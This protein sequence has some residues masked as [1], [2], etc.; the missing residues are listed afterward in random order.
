[1]RKFLLYLI[2]LNIVLI[3]VVSLT[4][5]I[6]YIKEK[7]RF[8]F[9]KKSNNIKI[10][11]IITNRILS[12]NNNKSKEENEKVNFFLKNYNSTLF[13]NEELKNDFI[14]L[15]KKYPSN[16]SL[17]NYTFLIQNKYLIIKLINGEFTGYSYYNHSLDETKFYNSFFE[18]YEQSRY[19]N[20]SNFNNI[21]LF[22]Y[23]GKNLTSNEEM[24]IIHKK[25][26]TSNKTIFLISNIDDIIIDIDKNNSFFKLKILEAKLYDDEFNE[27]QK[28]LTLIQMIF[29]LKYDSLSI[30]NNNK[31]KLIKFHSIENTDYFIILK[32]TCLK[33]KIWLSCYKK[34]SFFN[35]DSILNKINKKAINEKEYNI[36][37]IL[38][39]I[40]SSLIKIIYN[41]KFIINLIKNKITIFSFCIESFHLC[42]AYYYFLYFFYSL[43]NTK[44]SFQEK[45]YFGIKFILTLSS[46]FSFINILITF[47]L[48]P[49]FSF[50]LL[51]C[52]K[53]RPSCLQILSFYISLLINVALFIEIHP[54]K[55]FIIIPC[56][57]WA[58][59]I[60]QNIICSNKYILPL[61][62]YFFFTIEKFIYTAIDDSMIVQRPKKILLLLIINIIEITIIF[63]QGYY[64]PRFMFGSLCKEKN[65][66]FL[67]SKEELLREKPNCKNELCSI[68]LFPLFD[69]N[70]DNI[71]N[72][73][74]TKTSNELKSEK[75]DFNISKEILKNENINN[76]ITIIDNIIEKKNKFKSSKNDKA[77][78]NIKKL[79]DIIKYIIKKYFWDYYFNEEKFLRKYTLLNCGH[80]FHSECINLWINEERICPICRQPIL[81][82]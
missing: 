63:I 29:L 27:K 35:D 42:H 24:L 20:Y 39:I 71:N 79:K 11:K 62:Y 46:I 78:C 16:I 56:I 51:C 81:L 74:E 34:S 25:D 72:S 65:N 50:I 6:L 52:R 22:F 61:F 14:D 28:C 36:K 19:F 60:L 64:G 75:D 23:K 31:N 38:V 49:F 68:C 7:N 66:T 1:M 32:P 12:N 5:I 82:S 70:K 57:T 45:N 15:I 30:S 21:E 8:Y 48:I 77:K 55:Y 13:S 76:K 43:D 18:F 37:L 3:N 69:K 4:I 54:E 67:R 9:L 10:N 59:Q 53:S 44:Q 58:T 40:F 17:E 33:D 2:F 41:L 73:I 80:F 26:F 47:Y